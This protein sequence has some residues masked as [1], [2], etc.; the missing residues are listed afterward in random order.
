MQAYPEIKRFVQETLG[1]SCPEEVFNKIDY[2]KNKDNEIWEKKINIGNRLLIYIINPD[3]NSAIHERVQSA[4]RQ[5]VEE[6]NKKG[7]NRF[8]LVVVA[9]QP[10]EQE[11]PIESTFAGSEYVDDRTHLHVVTESEVEGI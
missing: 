7:F 2:T 3:K 8:R 1:C 6:R 4:L 9:S 10:D 11:G 5:G